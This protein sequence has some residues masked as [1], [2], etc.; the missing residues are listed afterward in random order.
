MDGENPLSVYVEAQVIER[1]GVALEMLD[2]EA[3]RRVLLWA[4][5]RYV[6]SELC[7]AAVKGKQDA[8]G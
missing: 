8:R 1:V 7:T 4:W 6:G 5:R 2:G 3:R